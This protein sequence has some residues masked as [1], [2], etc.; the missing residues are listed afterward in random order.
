MAQEYIH[1]LA[2]IIEIKQDLTATIVRGVLVSEKPGEEGFQRGVEFWSSARGTSP[3]RTLWIRN[4]LHLSR[5]LSTTF[6]FLIEIKPVQGWT[7]TTT[8]GITRKRRRNIWKVFRKK[9]RKK[10]RHSASPLLFIIKLRFSKNHR[11]RSR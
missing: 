7:A 5:S 4:L 8:H 9:I 6:F 10:P 2:T 1:L 3:Q 11:S